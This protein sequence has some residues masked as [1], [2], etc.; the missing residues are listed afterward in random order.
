MRLMGALLILSGCTGLGLWYRE[1]FLGR[2]RVLRTF[3]AILEMLISEIRYGKSTLS[4]GC[5]EVA[6]RVEEPYR[7]VLLRVH[8]ECNNATGISFGEVFGAQMEKLFVQLP[9]KKEDKEIFLKPFKNQGFQFRLKRGK[10]RYSMDKCQNCTLEEMICL[11]IAEANR[12]TN[13]SY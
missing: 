7:G 4:E 2:L 9:V 8:Q 5:K 13:G 12:F 3:T 1:Q 6:A 10:I 11:K